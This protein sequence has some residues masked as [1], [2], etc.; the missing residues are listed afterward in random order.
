[1]H[2]SWLAAGDGCHAGLGLRFC[3]V[4]SGTWAEGDGKL[5]LVAEELEVLVWELQFRVQRL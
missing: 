5:R 3:Y 2:P 1:M 4:K